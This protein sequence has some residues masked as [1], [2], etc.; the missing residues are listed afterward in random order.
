MSRSHSYAQ[1]PVSEAHDDESSNHPSSSTLSDSAHPLRSNLR[2]IPSSTPPSAGSSGY[3]RIQNEEFD[4]IDE[5]EAN[6]MLRPLSRPTDTEITVEPSLQPQQQPTSA[7]A[8]SSQPAASAPAAP[9]ATRPQFPAA[10]GARRMIQQTMDGVFSNLSAKPR[11][12]KPFQEELPPPYKAA[13]LDQSPIYYETT[14]VAPGYLDDEVLVDGLPVGGFIGF[15]WNMIISMSFQF[16]G[17]FLTYLLHTSH[18][19]K[20]GS[21]TGLG[22][23]FITMGWQMLSGKTDIDEE[24]QDGDTGYIGSPGQG[25]ASIKEYM[26]LSYF[27][28]FLGFAIILQSG[29]EFLKAKR[30]E[31]V[32][33]ATSSASPSRAAE[34]EV[35]NDSVV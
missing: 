17:F 5:D 12:E 1:I 21:K 15:M 13:A 25:M 3:S 6:V 9:A 32:I 35:V 19:T 31:M 27:L 28:M 10:A 22:I 2:R 24:D 11:V 26:W 23:T 33:N 4:E 14:V 30:T 29:L 8:S 7:A 16:V 18:A 34:A 20:N